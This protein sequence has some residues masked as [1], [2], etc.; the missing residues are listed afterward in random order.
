MINYWIFK[1]ADDENNGYLK[2]GISIYT[3]RMSEFF[4]G[5]KGITKS[6]RKAANVDS[7]K[8]GDDV[9]FYLVGKGGYCFLGTATLSSGFRD[10]TPDESAR[11]THKEYLDWEQGVSLDK[12]QFKFG[13]SLY[14]LNV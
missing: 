7:L 2:Q 11:I 8:R 13:R 9:L 6:G 1:V 12:T 3:H 4:W 10:L 5:V 14:Q